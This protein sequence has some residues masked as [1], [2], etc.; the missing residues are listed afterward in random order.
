MSYERTPEIRE[1]MRRALLGNKNAL[2]C[3]NTPEQRENKRKAHLG[4]WHS[5]E[6]LKKIKFGSRKNSGKLGNKS[7]TGQKCSVEHIRKVN[8]PKN[9]AK[10]KEGMKRHA[11]LDLPNCGCFVHCKIYAS[12]LSWRMIDKFL[13]Q[14]EIVIAEQRFD[15]YI[16]D[17]YLPEE[18]L[19][20]EADG[21][22]WH[23]LNEKKN[24]G[25]YT[26]RD[27]YL[28]KHFNLPVIHL[29]EKEINQ[30]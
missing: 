18:H 14:F 30:A 22:Y 20:F 21:S 7:R 9:I 11:A 26:T 16:V 2:G 19:A 28:L 1:K 8:T 24:P 29:S 10:R 27:A 23:E 3:K 17:A 25:Y 12:Q 15:S 6:T 13:N 4:K 5:P